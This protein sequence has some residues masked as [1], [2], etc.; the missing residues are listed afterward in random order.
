MLDRS[1]R[2]FDV[3]VCPRC[4]KREPGAELRCPGDGGRLIDLGDGDPL[5]GAVVADRFLIVDLLAEGGMGRIYRGH[6]LSMD[7]AVALKVL[8]GPLADQARV[9]RLYREARSIAQLASPHTVRA[10]DFGHLAG[11]EM[12]LAMELL[13]G[14]SLEE[15][16]ESE[17]P[18]EAP[19]ALRLIRQV[20]LSLAEAHEHGII[21]RDIK[22]SNVM[23]EVHPS[24]EEHVKVLDFGL[25]K[26][27]GGAES[28][29]E[30]TPWRHLSGT[31]Q[32]MAP[33]LWSAELGPPG[34]EAD[35]YAVGIV[36]Y[37]LLTGRGPFSASSAAGYMDRHL[38]DRPPR[39]DI[40]PESASL[41]ADVQRIVDRCLAKRAADR[42]AS[43]GDLKTAIDGILEKPDPHPR[44]TSPERTLSPRSFEHPAGLAKPRTSWMR[45][46]A[47][48]ALLPISWCI[49]EGLSCERARTAQ[50]PTVLWIESAPPGAS[51]LIDGKPIGAKTP[52]ELRGLIAHRALQISV[53]RPGHAPAGVELSLVPGVEQR[54]R[55][56]LDPEERR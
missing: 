6:Q 33:E 42:W 4:L 34:P 38:H 17:A 18:L 45:A 29:S 22:P 44:R 25:V 13:S 35:I 9:D 28:G 51:V 23:V 11:G 3:K 1:S 19:R 49:S 46:A 21:H 39:M 47:V 8:K 55:L 12:Y 14:R 52:I 26:L 2:G 30:A 56:E 40:R 27:T 32:Y 54:T 16:I 48:M 20:C 24:G 10:F 7:R 37:K 15:I 53:Q 31:P 43:A 5:I 41:V 36:L 50:P